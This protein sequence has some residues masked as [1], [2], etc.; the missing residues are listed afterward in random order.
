MASGFTGFTAETEARESQ[1]LQKECG[2]FSKM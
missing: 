2:R 1:I